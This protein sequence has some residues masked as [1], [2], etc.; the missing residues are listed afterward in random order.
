MCFDRK[1]RVELMSEQTTVVDF[2]KKCP[3]IL[4]CFLV[5]KSMKPYVMSPKYFVNNL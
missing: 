5:Y 2:E 4:V 3:K 1:S